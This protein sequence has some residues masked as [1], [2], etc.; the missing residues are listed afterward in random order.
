MAQRV[1]VRE[2]QKVGRNVPLKTKRG[3]QGRLNSAERSLGFGFNF[4]G[5]KN[6]AL[7][8]L[9]INVLGGA[10]ATVL[11]GAGVTSQLC[12]LTFYL[13]SVSQSSCRNQLQIPNL[14]MKVTWLNWEGDK[15][16]AL[17]MLQLTHWGLQPICAVC[18]LLRISVPM[19]HWGTIKSSLSSVRG[20]RTAISYVCEYPRQ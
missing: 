2:K 15:R 9:H 18:K 12:I 20:Q 8:Y 5:C 16:K 6:K 4:S 3:K 11:G 14:K 7:G 10:G 1:H 13:K 17:R 19:V